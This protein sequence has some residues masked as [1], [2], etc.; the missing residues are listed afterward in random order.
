[1]LS[2]GMERFFYI[3]G[4]G[5]QAGIGNRTNVQD[6]QILLPVQYSCFGCDGLPASVAKKMSFGCTCELFLGRQID[7]CLGVTCELKS[8]QY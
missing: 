2:K 8:R 4:N 6:V 3:F 1:M 5:G 7:L